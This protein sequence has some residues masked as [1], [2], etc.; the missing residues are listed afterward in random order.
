MTR[1]ILVPLDGSALAEAVLPQAA[2]LAH[3]NDAELTLFRVVAP[4]E[5]GQTNGWGPV[6]AT[7]RAGWVEAALAHV[8]AELEAV[9]VPL[10]SIGLVA[11]TEVLVA[12]DVASAII[13]RA[14]R[15]SR[16]LM[17]AMATHGRSGVGRWV[18][19]S[20]AEKVLLGAPTPLLL[21]QAREAASAD[22]CY[23]TIVV[24]LDG[25]AFAEQALGQAQA[26][27]S[28]TRA[29][30]VLVTVVPMLEDIALAEAG[31]VPAWLAAE[32]QAEVEYLRGYLTRI[33]AR[34]ESE[35]FV[36]RPRLVGGTT[37][38]EI[39]H[40]SIEEHADL[41]VMATHGH[42]GWQ[43]LWL[44][45]VATKLVRSAHL[46]VLLVRPQDQTDRMAATHRS[47][48]SDGEV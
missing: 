25:S 22:V 13:G 45:S 12:G 19:G 21:V 35:G 46:P 23:R 28:A 33:A 31:V 26:L 3:T 5:L 17:I 36:V 24:P 4:T 40:V 48:I 7:I 9:A 37:A 11:Q 1:Q 27:A 41:I 43:R 39:L 20:V 42:T 38:E 29:T 47:I 8:S 16:T 34:L 30:L 14:E 6:P 10:R 32:R 2:A 44:G 18:L 15:D